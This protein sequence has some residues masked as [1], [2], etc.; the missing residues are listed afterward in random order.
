[1]DPHEVRR[2]GAA[3]SKEAPLTLTEDRALDR[4]QLWSHEM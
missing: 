4:E 1:M 2:T 3:T